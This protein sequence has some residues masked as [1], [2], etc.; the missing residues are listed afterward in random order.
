M[1]L[2]NSSEEIRVLLTNTTQE[3][4]VL[5]HASNSTSTFTGAWIGSGATV[6]G[7]FAANLQNATANLYR[8][9]IDLTTEI[10]VQYVRACVHSL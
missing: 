1:I 7:T 8:H 3:A 5:T 9:L 4:S 10:E 2:S 6:P